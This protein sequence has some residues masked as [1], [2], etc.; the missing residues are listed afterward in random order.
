MPQPSFDQAPQSFPSMPSFPS[1][2][3]SNFPQMNYPSMP[4]NNY[5]SVPSFPSFPSYPQMP[6]FGSMPQGTNFPSLSSSQAQ[7]ISMP[8]QMPIYQVGMSLNPY[9]R[10]RIVIIP[11]APTN[12]LALLQVHRP[13]I[14]SQALMHVS[15]LGNAIEPAALHH[16]FYEF[17]AIHAVQLW[18]HGNAVHAFVHAQ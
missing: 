4:A 1:F 16:T 7:P 13:W 2:P 6:S 17:R 3:Q 5:P 14:C 10:T 8:Q 18:K 15:F 12:P 11:H 9:A